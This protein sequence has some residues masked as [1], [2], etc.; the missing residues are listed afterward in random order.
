MKLLYKFY[1]V[2]FCLFLCYGRADAGGLKQQNNNWEFA[3]WY[4]GGCYPSVVPDPNIKDRVYLLSDV[5]GLW[6]SD[7]KGDKWYF[8]NNGLINLHI[9]CL[10]V[11]PSDSNILYIGTKAGIMRSD[12]AGKT[13]YY[14]S[15]TEDKIIFERPYSYRCITVDPQDY[16]K[17]FAGTKAGKVF[18]SKD[19][20]Q[21]WKYLGCPFRKDVPITA[22]CLVQDADSLFVTSESGLRRYDFQKD[23][24]VKIETSFKKIWDIVFLDSEKTIYATTDNKIAYSYNYGKIWQF[25]SPIP[26]G[27][28]TRLSVRKNLSGDIELLVGWRDG[29]QGGV[30]LSLD[31][32]K[33][34]V[35]IERNLRH[36]EANNPTRAWTKNFGWANSVT[37]DTFNSET[38]YFTDWWGV[39]RSDDKGRS[40]NEK[41]FG[42]PNTVGSDIC[43]TSNGEIYAATMD[44]GLL[45][46]IDGGKT[47]EAI[48][49]KEGFNR[50]INGH[51]W[52]VIVNPRNPK[53]LIA[54]SSPWHEDINQ[55][56]ISRDG[57]LSFAVV[58]DGLPTKRPRVNTMWEEGYPKAIAFDSQQPHIVYLGIDGDDGGGLYVSYDGGWHWKYSEGQPGSRRIYNA[59]AVDPTNSNRLFW[60]AYGEKGGVY[61]SDDAGRRWK[62]AFKEMTK[63][64]DLA[65]NADGWIYVAGYSNGPAIFIS[66]DQGENWSLLKKFSGE[67]TAEALFIHPF[68]PG[69]MGISIVSWNG[70]ADGK[71]YWSEDS[72]RNWSEITGDL[73][74]GSGVAA[75]AYNPRDSHLYIIRYVGSVYK[76][77]C[78][79]I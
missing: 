5:A 41:I 22:L 2:Y 55:V 9:A 17:L 61:V 54:T 46:S 56:I 37:F 75:M 12:N 29:W 68:D 39:W 48:F 42:A 62:Y 44:N 52:R 19:G 14:L 32:G 31:N 34:W 26:Q 51:V 13:W 35:D 50:D 4:G 49:P 76:K 79:E 8:I 40:W 45:K 74:P 63:V 21:V 70:Y 1:I 20:G 60:G 27:E 7:N 33:S 58:R 10:A 6:R 57:G 77:N 72:G 16:N 38:L 3:G 64:F 59:L 23:K 43:I 53:N 47:Y 69:K 28:I 25:T 24:W 11:A 66:K 36:D 78:D 65:V 67:G 30:F 73:P 15:S 18:F 71:I